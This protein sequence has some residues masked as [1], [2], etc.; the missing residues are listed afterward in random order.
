LSGT[1]EARLRRHVATLAGEIGERH[2]RRPKALAA[3]EAYIA[4]EL[5]DI[6]HTVRR[7]TYD[8][9]GVASSNLEIEIPGSTAASEIVLA[10]AHY[11]TVPGSPGADDNGSG[12]AGVIEIARRLAGARPQRTIRLV[13]FVNEEPPFFYFGEMGSKVYAREARRRGDDI[14][15]M[16][17]LEMLGCYSARRGSQ[18]YPPLLA[19]FYPDR[20]DFIG[21]V[22]NLRSRGALGEL[23]RAFRE[24]SD[25]PMARLAAPALVPGVGLSDQISFW[26]Q[27]YRAVMVTDT[28]FYRYRHYHQSTD[29]P[30]R[31]D[32]AR[33]AEVVSGLAGAIARLGGIQTKL[34][35]G[36]G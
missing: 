17:S 19:R 28:A 34:G 35:E 11:D 3:A 16:L 22:S 33:M 18:Q 5:A 24:A 4:G 30:E 7:Q 2:V 21:F 8:A 14:R 12:V 32:Y 9:E 23:C 20:G 10:G 13:A 25:F 29:T 27:G 6:G 15:M 26:K 1:L 36:D 31:L